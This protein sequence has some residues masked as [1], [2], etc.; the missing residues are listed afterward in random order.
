MSPTVVI[1]RHFSI[2][3]K[4]DVPAEPLDLSLKPPTED[5]DLRDFVADFKRTR[6]RLGLT[7]GDVGASL[8]AVHGAEF[9]QTTISRFEAGNLSQRNMARLAPILRSWLQNAVASR[10]SGSSWGQGQQ[11]SGDG[12]SG[13]CG[14]RV[15][16]VA[17]RRRKRRTTIS[18]EAREALERE[19]RENPRP[20][21][22]EMMRVAADAG[23]DTDVARVWF[24]NR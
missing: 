8:G 14:G 23:V 24:N 5:G 15:E 6:T 1:H 10:S 17:V 11:K 2:M 3:T 4:S 20:C 19:F 22:A 13:V 7:Q 16:A 12:V 18:S 9:S 21:G